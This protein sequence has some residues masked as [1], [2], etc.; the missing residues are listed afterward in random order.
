MAKI[1]FAS[2]RYASAIIALL[3]LYLTVHV[4]VLL[5]DRLSAQHSLEQSRVAD[6]IFFAT[7]DHV[8]VARNILDSIAHQIEQNGRVSSQEVE[9][10]TRE[11]LEK[12]E[13]GANDLFRGVGIG[14]YPVDHYG[15]APFFVD[16]LSGQERQIQFLGSHE[17]DVRDILAVLDPD[18]GIS[19]VRRMPV[20]QNIEHPGN[21]LYFTRPVYVQTADVLPGENGISGVLF[22][23]VD[24]GE[25]LSRNARSLMPGDVDIRMEVVLG[26]SDREAV[27]SLLVDRYISYTGGHYY[28]RAEA[29]EA[30]SIWSWENWPLAAVL[31]FGILS[32]FALSTTVQRTI[33]RLVHM[34]GEKHAI[35]QRSRMQAEL[36]EKLIDML[37]VGVTVKDVSKDYRFVLVNK[38]WEEIVCLKREDVIGRNVLDLFDNGERYFAT[39]EAIVKA[40]LP[41]VIPCE[42]I[43]S[44][45]RERLIQKR[46]TP[47]LDSQGNVRYVVAVI[48]DIT[49]RMHHEEELAN[50]RVDLERLVA[51]RTA[52]LNEAVEEAKQA[53]RHKS[54]FLAVISH[55]IRSPMNGI[56]GMGELLLR[57]DLLPKQRQYAEGVQYSAS[58]LL[59]L[60]EDVLDLSK[61]E[62]GRLE[63]DL[64]ATN[65]PE[66]LDDLADYWAIRQQDSPVELVMRLDPD[67]PDVVMVDMLRLRQMLTNLLSNAF[68]F[69]EQG[70]VVVKCWVTGP[71]DCPVL[72]FSV[73]DTGIGIPKDAQS[74]IFESFRQADASTTRQYGGTGLGLAIT[75][76]LGELMGGKVDL[77]SIPGE[78]ACFIISIPLIVSDAGSVSEAT[79]LAGGGDTARMLVVDDMADVRELLVEAAG[80]A[81]WQCDARASG[82]D[83]FTT[84]LEAA[85]DEE[86][87]YDLVVIDELLPD[88][89]AESF[90]Q[91]VRRV[92]QLQDVC[93]VIMAKSRGAA[94]ESSQWLRGASG[95][96]H[97]PLACRDSI[98]AV[99]AVLTGTAAEAGESAITTEP[100]DAMDASVESMEFSHLRVLA[101]EDNRINRLFL[102]DTLTSLGCQFEIAANGLDAVQRAQSNDFDVILMDCLMPEMDGFEATRELCRLKSA[103]VVRDDLPIIALT[104]NA[105][106]GDRER[107]LNAGMDDY[108]SKPVRGVDLVAAFRKHCQLDRREQRDGS[109]EERPGVLP[110]SL[111]EAVDGYEVEVVQSGVLPHATEIGEPG[112]DMIR[113]VE[114]A[115][116]SEEILVDAEEVRRNMSVMRE[117]F[118]ITLQFYVEDAQEC[119]DTIR[120]GSPEQMEA[121]VRAA[122]SLKSM[123]RQIGAT[124]VSKIA[125]DMEARLRAA[126]QADEPDEALAETAA[127]AADLQQT[128]A[129]TRTQIEGIAAVS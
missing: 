65:V 10:L 119:V 117:R 116:Q 9:L 109:S 28:M 63:L 76:Q 84:L 70:S 106:K 27:E 22:S 89:T 49:E 67:V 127:Q 101:A 1:K 100:R 2:K 36:L 79:R 54:E 122:H 12:Y 51:E 46:K 118:P 92:P 126:E 11:L 96:V 111:S 26:R 107:C 83:G 43:R 108:L 112:N 68:K 17:I 120:N 25:V 78:G 104:A 121:V 59:T 103:G 5:A 97:K 86:A 42:R 18:A 110:D 69:T 48:D 74:A 40:K 102:E 13:S 93:L 52:S 8:A 91:S 32:T 31:G 58:L 71:A 33:V 7:E 56:I 90:V 35:E 61:I 6:E 99:H 82:A 114:S 105:M 53:N 21:D 115:Q 39:D 62:S 129:H 30:W 55:E 88:M 128:I 113:D 80:S 60:I 38:R 73:R 66:F 34:S 75:R 85:N 23:F 14:W 4:S 44:N 19:A 94:A 47:V 45:N 20:T 124:A 15:S 50:H 64:V 24:V 123:S 87:R 3:G 29:G 41:E 72:C 57:T 81:G 77:E 37:P 125:K 95:V 16:V 98:R